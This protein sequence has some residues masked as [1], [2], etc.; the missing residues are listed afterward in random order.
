MTVKRIPTQSTCSVFLSSAHLLLFSIRVSNALLKTILLVV[1]KSSLDESSKFMFFDFVSLA[2]QK[3]YVGV[4]L[5]MLCLD[6]HLAK[7]Q[8]L[9]I[10]VD[11]VE[12]YL[13]R[14]G[15]DYL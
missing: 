4:C 5:V 7:S 11:M 15:S 10:A 2:I 14:K 12:E 13:Q 1:V 9:A 3:S 8:K 6:G